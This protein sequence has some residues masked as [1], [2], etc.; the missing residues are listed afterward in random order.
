MP[1]PELTGASL[2]VD[3]AALQRNYRRLADAAS[4]GLAG[5]AVKADAYGLGLTPVC[6]A[7]WEA[8][9]RSFFVAFPHEGEDLRTILPDAEIFV[10]N[11]LMAGEAPYY[12]AHRL[13]PALAQPAEL[14]EWADFCRARGEK[15]AAAIH[16]DTGIHRLGFSES[17]LRAIAPADLASFTLALVMS[18]LA[19]ADMPGSEMNTRQIAEFE[20]LAGLLPKARRSLANSPGTLG[21]K[22]AVMDLARPGIALYG[23]N[24][25]G[26]GPNPFE[27]VACL[28]APVLQLCEVAA[29]EGIGYSSSFITRRAS[30]IAII[31]VGYGDGYPRALSSGPEGGPARVFIEGRHAPLVGRISMDMLAVDVT[32]VP[33]VER[34]SRAELLGDH[35]SLEELARLSGTISYEILTRLGSRHARIYSELESLTQGS[36]TP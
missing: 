33:G 24:P 28:S 25:F 10:L 22:A 17:Q 29:G 27:V 32:D 18:H 11:G 30:R 1:R 12:A 9:C 5:A 21:P 19:H 3:L 23:G 26:A 6:R 8:G 35:V 34:G 7:L 13:I 20:R 14:A 2:H 31:G 15:L 36:A 16:F 4:P